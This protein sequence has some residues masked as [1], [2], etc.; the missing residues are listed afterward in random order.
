VKEHL[1]VAFKRFE[2]NL[3]NSSLYEKLS[4]KV[5]SNVKEL[6]IKEGMVTTS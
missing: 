2:I 5:L 4:V 3:E 1:N 6:L